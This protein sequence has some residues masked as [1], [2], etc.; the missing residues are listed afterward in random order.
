M[1]KFASGSAGGPEAASIAASDSAGSFDAA[2]PSA[3]APPPSATLPPPIQ[4]PKEE[5]H[6]ADAASPSGA[7]AGSPAEEGDD[8]PAG[9]QMWNAGE[10]PQ[11]T[12]STQVLEKL[13]RAEMNIAL[14]AEALGAVRVHAQ[15]SGD[16]VGAAITVERRDAHTLLANNLAALHEALSER[17]LRVQDISLQHAPSSGGAGAQDRTAG[18]E[19]Q[20]RRAGYTSSSAER[21]QRFAAATQPTPIL[22]STETRAIFNSEGRLSV[23][24]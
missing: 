22:D 15:V 8:L 9:L 7:L 11:A 4:L 14:Q 5:F 3:P 21:P 20:E 16:Q 6:Y 18:Q 17:H 13:G 12:G 10:G 2:G 1:E 19:P 24:A 23:R